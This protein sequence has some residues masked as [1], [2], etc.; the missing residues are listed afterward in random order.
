M[1]FIKAM[2]VVAVL[3]LAACD[4][5]Q[6]AQ[7][8]TGPPPATEMPAAPVTGEAPRQDTDLQAAS[9]ATPDT[10]AD[11]VATG[12]A[13]TIPTDSTIGVPQTTLAPPPTP[14][15]SFA[16]TDSM[17]PP[18]AAATGSVLADAPFEAGAYK[19]GDLRL[20]LSADGDFSFTRSDTGETVTGDFRV[21]GDMMTFSNVGTDVAPGM[22]PMTCR[23]A[24]APQGFQLTADGPSCSL[25]DGQTFIRG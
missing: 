16:G 19:V 5:P 9:P 21:Y 7:T 25:F 6:T 8:E 3:A 15:S 14:S 4:D 12:Q 11:P 24:P 20:E 18:D 2:P 23:V 1:R 13:Q 22:F 10:T 17:P